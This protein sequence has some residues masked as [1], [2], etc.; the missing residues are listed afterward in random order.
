MSW[1]A[2]DNRLV[3]TI[4]CSRYVMMDNWSDKYLCKIQAFQKCVRPS[5]TEF[6]KKNS[7]GVKNELSWG[8]KCRAWYLQTWP[9][10]SNG[11]KR[12]EHLGEF[13]HI[14]GQHEKVNLIHLHTRA[15]SKNV[16]SCFCNHF[17]IISSRLAFKMYS[18]YPWIKLVLT[19]C[20]EEEK[21]KWKCR[22]ER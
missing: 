5:L 4:H 22:R 21:Q 13:V 9:T 16:T 20:R 18:N 2:L 11:E 14:D 6:E 10:K 3:G 8:L 1:R 15:S 7:Y 17:S 12:Y 19:V